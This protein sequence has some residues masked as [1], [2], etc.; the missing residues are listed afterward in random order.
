MSLVSMSIEELREEVNRAKPMRKKGRLNGA[1]AHG[2]DGTA[3]PLVAEPAFSFVSLADL[4]ENPPP[5]REWIVREWLPRGTLVALF[6][7]GGIGK[8]LLAQQ[9]ATCVA[10]GV[11]TLG[12]DVAPSPVLALFGEDDPEELRRRQWAILSHLERS[13]KYSADGLHLNG[14]AGLEN[15]LMTFTADR[16]PLAMPLMQAL[17]DECARLRPALVVLDNIAQVFGGMENDRHQVTM[18]ANALTG[19]AREFDCCVLLLGH[20]AKAQGSEYSGSTAWE[21]AVR[22][23]LWLERRADGMIELH[24]AKANYAARGSVVMEY[25]HGA[26]VEI[27]ESRG[28]ESDVVRATEKQVLDALDALTSRQI[29]SSQ[30]PTASTYLP[31]LAAKQGLI[32][33]MTNAARALAALIERGE[34][35]VGQQLGWKKSDRH[36]AVGLARKEAS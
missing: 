13:P 4:H 30:N 10:N 25:R 32:T 26:L 12:Q 21:A 35:L 20:V 1:A 34:I 15:T 17:R 8:S 24:K 27:D 33:N 14:R 36:P 5:E 11:Q 29:A 6:G 9:I 3:G 2:E 22:T 18:F 16:I 7:G 23:R 31:R 19:L 28:D